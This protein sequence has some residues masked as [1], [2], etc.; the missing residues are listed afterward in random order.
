MVW[1][2]SPEY[3]AR[4]KAAGKRIALDHILKE[5][6]IEV[7]R[8][9]SSP[10]ACLDE[11]QARVHNRFKLESEPGSHEVHVHAEAASYADEYFETVRA[12]LQQENPTEG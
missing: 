8:M 5:L 7:A 9:H 2:G 6:L 1:Y 4:L 12:T 3:N 10:A 11:L